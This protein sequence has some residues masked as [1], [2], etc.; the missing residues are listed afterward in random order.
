MLK[1][2][3]SQTMLESTVICKQQQAFA[4]MIE[5]SNGIDFGYLDIIGERTRLVFGPCELAM[6]PVRFVEEDVSQA[7][8]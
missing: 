3:V 6:Y 2:G 8:W 4:I 7:P 1:L 5:A